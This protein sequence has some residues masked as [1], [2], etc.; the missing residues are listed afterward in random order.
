M[1]SFF[2]YIK[3]VNNI[4][5]P[6]AVIFHH[7]YSTHDTV[8]AQLLCEAIWDRSLFRFYVYYHFEWHIVVDWPSCMCYAGE[9][10]I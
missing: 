7:V 10:M 8:H 6:V 9:R 2:F 4:N 3:E 5:I 1:V